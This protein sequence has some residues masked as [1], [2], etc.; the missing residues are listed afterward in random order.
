MLQPKRTKFRKAHKGRIHGVASSAIDLAFGQFGLKATEPDRLASVCTGAMILAAAGVL[1]GRAATTRRTSVGAEALAPLALLADPAR[2]VKAVPAA[3]VD[4]V[5][6]TGGGVSLAIDTTLYL[7]GKIYGVDA[8]NDVAR[9][10]EYDR[11]FKANVDALGVVAP[12]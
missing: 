4:D 7:I 3:I 9:I 2:G 6:V 1:E 10:I 8:R 12:H 11:A 5:V